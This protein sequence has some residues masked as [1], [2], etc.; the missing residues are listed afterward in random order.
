MTHVNRVSGDVTFGRHSG[1][2]DADVGTMS[3]KKLEYCC[4]PASDQR[5]V[6]ISCTRISATGM[7]APPLRNLRKFCKST[8]EPSWMSYERFFETTVIWN[9]GPGCAASP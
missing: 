2:T 1:A 6:G 7:L 9:N 3:I 4:R 5:G 8:E